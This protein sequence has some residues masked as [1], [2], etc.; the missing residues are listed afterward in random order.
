MIEPPL[1]VGSLPSAVCGEGL[2]DQLLWIQGP[3]SP[4]VML[5]AGA[6]LSNHTCVLTAA[7]SLCTCPPP[8][9]GGQLVHSVEFISGAQQSEPVTSVLFRILFPDKSSQNTEPGSLCQTGGPC[10]LSAFYA[11]V[12]VLISD[13]YLSLS[14]S[15]T[16]SLLSMSIF[17]SCK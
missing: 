6:V 8:F 5:S 11:L 17:L 13:G 16:L 14:P 4:F 12:F 1:M 7:Q 10:W 9:T 2:Q 3:P 15:V